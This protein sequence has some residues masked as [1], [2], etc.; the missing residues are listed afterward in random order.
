VGYAGALVM[1][2]GVICGESSIPE[3]EFLFK[4]ASDNKFPFQEG[5][6]WRCI[7]MTLSQFRDDTMKKAR[8]AFENAIEADTRNGTRWSLAMDYLAYADLL[9][10]GRS[11]TTARDNQEKALAVFKA[12]GADG[13]SR[14][15]ERRLTTNS[16]VISR[17]E[18]IRLHVVP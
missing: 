9:E 4:V 7:G 12:C 8:I 2:A 16:Q 10:R 18:E 1:L 11:E 14:E 3:P 15:V 13:W 5:S 6:I 17:T